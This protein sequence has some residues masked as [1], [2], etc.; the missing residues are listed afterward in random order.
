MF[1]KISQLH[2]FF[3]F[4]FD[5]IWKHQKTWFYDTVF[6]EWLNETEKK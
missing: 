3:S 1:L 2:V 5:P 6:Q 4:F